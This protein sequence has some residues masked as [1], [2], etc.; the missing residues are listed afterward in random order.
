M[1]F[2]ELLVALLIDYLDFYIQFNKL[3]FKAHIFISRKIYQI[4]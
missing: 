3:K 4:Y 2:K 1:Y